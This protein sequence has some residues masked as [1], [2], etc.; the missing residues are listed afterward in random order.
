MTATTAPA[1]ELHPE[2]KIEQTVKVYLEWDAVNRRYFIDPVTVDG[3]P[4]DA[5]DAPTNDLF[6]EYWTEAETAAMEAA[7]R[8]PIPNADELALL[9]LAALPQETKTAAALAVLTDAA[10]N[11][12]SELVT[13]VAKG[14]EEYGNEESAANQ[15]STAAS[16]NAAIELLSI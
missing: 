5:E 10:G 13:Y 15:R 16:I 8:A 7:Q 12:A 4:L 1:P 2:S 11:W 3:H 14:S 6:P 9:L